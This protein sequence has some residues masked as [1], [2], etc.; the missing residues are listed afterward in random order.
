ML[1]RALLLLLVSKV[2]IFFYSGI[3]KFL[4]CIL[5]FAGSSGVTNF[6]NALFILPRPGFYSNMRETA[7]NCWSRKSVNPHDIAYILTL[8]RRSGRAQS[9]ASR[10][11]LEEHVWFFYNRNQYWTA[12]QT[13]LQR[14][15]GYS[16]V[17]WCFEWNRWV[18][19]LLRNL[20][21]MIYVI[22]VFEL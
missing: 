3:H 22:L 2:S 14:Y 7:Q 17:H 13:W 8:A 10:I 12:C 4:Y 16:L 15:T 6:I 5:L 21:C 19:W 1:S 20:F 11:I 9:P 18:K